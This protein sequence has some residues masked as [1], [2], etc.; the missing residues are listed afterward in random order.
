MPLQSTSE[1]NASKYLC[2]HAYV[3]ALVQ[4]CV[5]SIIYNLHFTFNLKWR[6]LGAQ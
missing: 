1:Y 3:C 6:I 2:V 5:Q 4:A